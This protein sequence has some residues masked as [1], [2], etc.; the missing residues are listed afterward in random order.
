[1]QIHRRGVKI[2]DLW[3]S[4]AVL[5]PYREQ[6]SS[7]GGRHKGKWVIR[8][9]PRDRRYVF[10]QDPRTH[11]WHVLRWT[12]LPPGD[13]VP[14]FSDARMRELLAEARRRGLTPRSDAEL[15]P[16]LLEVLADHAPVNRWPTQQQAAP[17]RHRTARAREA[18]QTAA[19][20]RD[21]PRHNRRPTGAAPANVVP[22][23]RDQHARQV[24]DA[25]DAERR[26]RREQEVPL[27]PPPS[28]R[29]GETA[30]RR[31]L[32]LLPPDDP[33]DA[34]DP[35]GEAGLPASAEGE[36]RRR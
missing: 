22:L 1:V 2:L 12:G 16:V 10:F 5:D 19:A 25:I 11:A 31:N 33:G 34:D 6:L 18:A 32:L 36:D 26:R 8:R 17:K 15:L 21:R 7:I 30:R 4:G 28:S 29:L 23:D 24:Q 35:P 13:E 9:D 3:Y 27:T 20:Q 14:A